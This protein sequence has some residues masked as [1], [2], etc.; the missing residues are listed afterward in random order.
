MTG[1]LDPERIRSLSAAELLDA[2][3]ALP[4]AAG[5]Y[6]AGRGSASLE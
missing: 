2:W 4:A 6:R 5:G 1:D 3:E